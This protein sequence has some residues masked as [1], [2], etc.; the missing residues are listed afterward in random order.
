M[1][2]LYTTSAPALTV[3]QFSDIC[4]SAPGEC[5]ELPVIQA[6]VGGALDLLATL[7]EQTEYL[8]TLYCKEPQKL[9]DVAAIVRFMQQQPEQFANSNAMLLLIRYFEQ[10]GGCEK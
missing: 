9:F 10:Y 5:S 7:D 2:G 8:E 4:A 6:Y 3:Q 1:L